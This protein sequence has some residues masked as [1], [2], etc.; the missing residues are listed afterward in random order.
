MPEPQQS[1]GLPLF[2]QIFAGEAQP[3]TR[4]QQIF[5]RWKKFHAENPHVWRLFVQYTFEVINTGRTRYSPD[6]ILHR[7]RWNLEVETTGSDVKINN[8]LSSIYSRFFSVSYPEHG[9]FY[10]QR[11]RT[12][13]ERSAY[14]SD[15]EVVPFEMPDHEAALIYELTELAHLNSAS[16]S[17]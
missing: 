4:G 6:A 7:I 17:R 5:N 9:A 1:G 11:K 10:E 13:E 15:L 8:D 14:A 12:S 16:F 2:D 3:T